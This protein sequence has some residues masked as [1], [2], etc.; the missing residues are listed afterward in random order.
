M[1]WR[2]FFATPG[3]V[4]QPPS[5]TSALSTPSLR[6]L[7]VDLIRALGFSIWNLHKVCS[8]RNI[9]KLIMPLYEVFKCYL[10]SQVLNEGL[11]FISVFTE[12]KPQQNGVF[13]AAR[14]VSEREK[15]ST[16]TKKQSLLQFPFLLCFLIFF[17]QKKKLLYYMQAN[18]IA[19]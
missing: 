1:K 14:S 2:R 18:K 17:L 4:T 3:P 7:H 8:Q 15:C 12:H 6:C 9:L 5:A 11:H 19:G 16:M 10:V 13:Q